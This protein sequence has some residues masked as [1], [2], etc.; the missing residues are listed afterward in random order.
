[1]LAML[2]VNETARLE[3]LLEGVYFVT[4]A[5]ELWTEALRETDK[6]A[7]YAKLTE[8]EKEMMPY[9]DFKPQ[10]PAQ[11]R[12]GCASSPYLIP[13]LGPYLNPYLNVSRRW[14]LFFWALRCNVPLCFPALPW[15]HHTHC[16]LNTPLLGI[17]CR[18]HVFF[19]AQSTST[20][21]FSSEP[22]DVLSWVPSPLFLELNVTTL[23]QQPEEV[24]HL[25]PCPRVSLEPLPAE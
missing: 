20:L 9:E 1:M 25:P 7:E 11:V 19:F 13:Q 18:T 17:P 10:T 15:R 2:E 4:R 22:F 12:C 16:A 24:P 5:L 14:G 3:R 8:A 21:E 23:R 6:N